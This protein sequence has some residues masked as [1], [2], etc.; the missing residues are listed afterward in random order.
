MMLRR[1]RR[2]RADD[3]KYLQLTS[4]LRERRFSFAA[5]AAAADTAAAAADAAADI[6]RFDPRQ[7][8]VTTAAVGAR[9]SDNEARGGRKHKRCEY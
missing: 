9:K 4:W 7:L 6:F 5:A 8:E 3:R 2:S 1:Q